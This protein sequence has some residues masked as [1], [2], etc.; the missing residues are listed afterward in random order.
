MDVE[1]STPDVAGDAR[2]DRQPHRRKAGP[3]ILI[4]DDSVEQIALLR[5]YLESYG[6]SMRVCER[7][8]EA[9]SI[10]EQT[11]PDLILLAAD[12]DGVDSEAICRELKESTITYGIP[13]IVVWGRNDPEARVHGLRAGAVDYLISPIN[14]PELLERIRIHWRG[15]RMH[16]KLKRKVV[17]LRT[18]RDSLETRVAERTAELQDSL[19][20]LRDLYNNAPCGYHSLDARGVIVQINQTELRWLGYAEDEVVGRLRFLDLV[21]P[22]DRKAWFENFAVLKEHGELRDIEYR[23]LRK[24]GTHLPVLLNASAITDE[25]GR[26]VMSRATIFD[27]S[28]RRRA[29][30]RVRYV[31]HHDVLTGLLNRIAFKI[32]SERRLETVARSGGEAAILFIDLDNFKTIN[33][34]LGHYVGDKVIVEAARRIRRCIEPGDVVARFGGDEFVMLLRVGEEGAHEAASRLLQEMSLPFDV[35]GHELHAGATVG[36]SM[37]PRDGTDLDTLMRAADAAMYAGK[38]RQRGCVELF[39]PALA[40]EAAFRLAIASQIPAALDRNQ[41]FIEYQPQVDLGTG[42]VV[43]VEA[44]VRWQH[45]VLGRLGPDQFIPIAEDSGVIH[46]IGEW[47]M[48]SACETLRESARAGHGGLCMAVNVSAKQFQ[49]PQFERMIADTIHASGV[50]P[51][52]IELEITESLFVD[53]IEENIL[54]LQRLA[55]SGVSLAIDDFGVGYSGLGYLQRLPLHKLK[56]DRSFINGIGEPAPSVGE[57]LLL[58]Q[59][60]QPMAAAII[61]M[62]RTLNFSIVAEGVEAQAHVDFLRAHGCSIAQGYFFARP[63]SKEKLLQY[64]AAVAGGDRAGAGR[65]RG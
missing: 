55:R 25:A 35:D 41:F 9:L 10:A 36:I 30:D 6:A 7:P 52:N 4:I 44:L 49:S 11:Q 18:A 21:V 29:E 19:E 64:L 38:R 56:I 13:V 45:P 22:A 46:A 43:G 58:P 14:R 40:D 65:G 8:L 37:Y 34:S 54:M 57:R 23:L 3:T 5:G 61:S 42:R 28:E 1:T 39:A 20:K 53:H 2:A 51:R 60:R 17:E 59:P 32:A 63:I 62:A 27:I 24:D 48:H 50:D 33:D 15:R 47:V 26:F 12:L 16:R 31:A